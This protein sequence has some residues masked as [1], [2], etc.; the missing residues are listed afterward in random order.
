MRALTEVNIGQIGPLP[1]AAIIMCNFGDPLGPECSPD[2]SKKSTDVRNTSDLDRYG[3]CWLQ[4]QFL[5]R[6]PTNYGQ[7]GGFSQVV[8]VGMPTGTT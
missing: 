1:T 4:A 5:D 6:L 3:M 7:P 2:R 8:P